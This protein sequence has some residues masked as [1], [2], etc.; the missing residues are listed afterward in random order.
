MNHFPVTR[1]EF[2]SSLAFAIIQRLSVFVLFAYPFDRDTFKLLSLY[3]HRVELAPKAISA[4]AAATF[5]VELEKPDVDEDDR[6]F[7]KP[8]RSSQRWRK[9]AKRVDSNIL[10]DLKLFESLG[11]IVPKSMEEV[12]TVSKLL[13]DEHKTILKVYHLLLDQSFAYLTLLQFYLDRLRYADFAATIQRDF[14]RQDIILESQ[15]APVVEEQSTPLNIAV[16]GTGNTPSAYPMVQPMKA[17]DWQCCL[18]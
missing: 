2:S 16:D 11:L 15:A 10:F 9:R 12:E 14:I 3:R 6:G 5:S 13:I 1:D 8:Q 7:I 4:L 18:H 17:W